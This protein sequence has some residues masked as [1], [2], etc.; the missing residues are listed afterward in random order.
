MKKLGSVADQLAFRAAIEQAEASLGGSEK[1]VEAS[2]EA[3]GGPEQGKEPQRPRRAPQRRVEARPKLPEGVESLAARRA[4]QRAVEAQQLVDLARR[5][6][7]TGETLEQIARAA[8]A[9]KAGRNDWMFAMISTDQNAAVVDW[10]LD[11]SKRP[12]VAVKLWAHLFRAIRTDT[13]E[14]LL[15]RSELADRVGLLPRDLSS[16]MTELASINAVLRERSGRGVRYFMNPHIATHVPGDAARAAA[17]E[18]AG[19][20]LVVVQDSQARDGSS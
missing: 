12:Q 15:S 8:G 17:R 10:L 9:M 11:N 3:S 18:K 19:P 4:R 5:A 1:P 6:G 7:I 20:I 14:I 16:I 2:T 13:G